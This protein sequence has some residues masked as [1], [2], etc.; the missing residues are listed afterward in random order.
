[1][2]RPSGGACEGWRKRAAGGGPQPEP[3][4][5]PRRKRRGHGIPGGPRVS[6]EDFPPSRGIPRIHS[7]EDVKRGCK[8]LCAA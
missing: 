2:A 1:M 7:G 6:S 5:N 4:V 3:G 8:M